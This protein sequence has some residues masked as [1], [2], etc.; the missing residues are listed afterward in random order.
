MILIPVFKRF[1]WTLNVGWVLILA[2]PVIPIAI[3]VRVQMLC[4]LGGILIKIYFEMDSLLI[5]TIRKLYKLTCYIINCG[6]V[7][8]WLRYGAQNIVMR[9]TLNPS[10]RVILNKEGG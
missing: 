1:N 5:V 2:N 7:L 9:V 6:V 8:T 4:V 3:L 10:L